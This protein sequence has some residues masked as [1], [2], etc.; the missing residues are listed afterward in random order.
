MDKAGEWQKKTEWH[1]VVVWNKNAQRAEKILK[2]GM[3]VYVEGKLTHRK[4]QDDQGNNRYTT[5]VVANSYRLLEKRERTDQIS[6]GSF[7]SQSDA[8]PQLNTTTNTTT[9]NSADN[10][11]TVAPTVEDDLPF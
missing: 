10:N 3:M 8:T 4:W 11:N 2:K 7:P 6:G 1:D 5:E 9:N